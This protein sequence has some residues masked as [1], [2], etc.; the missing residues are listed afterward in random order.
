MAY[1]EKISLLSVC[2]EI[3]DLF[4][5]NA[6]LL[7]RGFTVSTDTFIRF[8]E[9][10]CEDFSSFSG[11]VLDRKSSSNK[12]TFLTTSS[13][14]GYAI[15]PHG[16]MYYVPQRPTILWF[17]C[18]SPSARAG[19]TTLCE[20]G[21]V[22]NRLPQNVMKFFS[23]NRIKY[24]R[25]FRNGEWQKAF[26]T[27]D[28]RQVEESCSDARM[29][30]SFD[31]HD[32]SLRT[33]FICDATV[34]TGSEQLFINNILPIYADEWTYQLGRF[35]D[36]V[37]NRTR[38]VPPIV[39]R[40]ESGEK[41]PSAIIL[42]LRKVIEPITYEHSWN[43]GDVLIVNNKRMLHGRRAFSGNERVIFLRL[44]GRYRF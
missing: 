14:S 6:A 7:L 18:Q 25:F 42:E 35:G 1:P 15:P 4:Q 13:S 33:E 17:Y 11:G 34:R 12:D 22:F 38:T 19:E 3:I 43:E 31:K 44:G 32:A 20:S 2:R 29:T 28:P 24:I 9:Y 37:H 26:C 10:F 39:V 27:A 30:C 21:E 23:E 16:E 41:I 40:T 36:G 5:Q 8:T